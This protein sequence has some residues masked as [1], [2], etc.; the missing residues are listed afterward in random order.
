MATVIKTAPERTSLA[1]HS[2][3]RVEAAPEP[4]ERLSY[5]IVEVVLAKGESRS[6]QVGPREYV[7]LKRPRRIT[8]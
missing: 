1:W 5:K 6:V 2:P 7:T 3:M 8:A 4:L